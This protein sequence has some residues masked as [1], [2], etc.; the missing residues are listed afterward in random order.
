MRGAC[1]RARRSLPK[2]YCTY[3]IARPI[4]TKF[5]VRAPLEEKVV[6][7]LA[8]ARGETI[9]S[10]GAAAANALGLTAQVPV[11]TIYL[12]S[13]PSRHL[14]LGKQMIELRHAR[15]WQLTKALEPV[16]QAIRAL[17]WLGPMQADR[18]LVTL[19]HRLTP[20]EFSELQAM[21]SIL[22]EWLA[23][24]VSSTLPAHV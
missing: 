15:S 5:G 10:H 14:T 21:R 19:K 1:P 23:E 13:G 20:V 11:K 16:G 17:A 7:K 12:T 4:E 22:P 18:A 24:K 2:D 8:S 6:E 3:P 9:V